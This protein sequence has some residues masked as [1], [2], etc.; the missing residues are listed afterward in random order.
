MCYLVERLVALMALVDPSTPPISLA[1]VA[2]VILQGEA[3]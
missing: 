2:N 3:G 1:F